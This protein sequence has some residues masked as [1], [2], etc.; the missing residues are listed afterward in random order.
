ML[1]AQAAVEA[2]ASASGPAASFRIAALDLLPGSNVALDA[3]SSV[4]QGGRFIVSYDWSLVGS[5]AS[6][7]FS[8]GDPYSAAG[9]TA[10]VQAFSPDTVTLRLTVTDDQGASAWEE[11][12]LRIVAGP[13]AAML[14]LANTHPAVGD[15]VGLSSAGSSAQG[16]A[17]VDGYFWDVQTASGLASISGPADES[18]ATLSTSAAGVVTVRLTV[19]DSDGFSAATRQ[20][21]TIAPKPSGSGGGGG[22]A[23]GPLW[24]LGLL[25]L[26]LR[27]RR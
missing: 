27:I 6:A 26:G 23:F 16:A 10:S 25:L 14:T 8:G 17:F 3:S 24:A 2:A 22:G 19:T 21:V 9:A 15:T 1:D 5:P 13:P 12:S 20:S 7:R 18:T 11:Q 4:A